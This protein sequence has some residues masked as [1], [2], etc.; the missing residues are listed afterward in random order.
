MPFFNPGQNTDY[1]ML[2]Y[3]T[4]LSIVTE[5]KGVATILGHFWNFCNVSQVN[6]LVSSL[7]VTLIFSNHY[8]KKYI[9]DRSSVGSLR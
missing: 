4:I 3:I 9:T 1:A 2:D 7:I 5:C 6:L 8:P